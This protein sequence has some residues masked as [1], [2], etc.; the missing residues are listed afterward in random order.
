V[1]YGG[2]MVPEWLRSFISV[3]PLAHVFDALRNAFLSGQSHVSVYV[4]L[5]GLFAVAVLFL[6]RS[7]F[8]RASPRFEEAL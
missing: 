4:L 7:V 2:A 1:L 8:H 6:G 3:N 5:A